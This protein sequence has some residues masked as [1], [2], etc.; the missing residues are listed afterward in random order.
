MECTLCGLPATPKLQYEGEQFCCNGCREVYRYFG[1]IS[2]AKADNEKLQPVTRPEGSEAYLRIDGMHC[3]SCE[4]LIE[5]HALRVK[6]VVAAKTNYATGTLKVIYDPGLI[7]ETDLP[8][9]ISRSGYP[10]RF[11]H[12]KAPAYDYRMP[13][14]RLVTGESLAATVMMLYLAFYY[15]LHL[16][17]I[18]LAE[19]EPVHWLVHQAVPQVL[20]LLTSIMVVYVAAPI[21]RGAWVGL[22]TGVLNMD[23]LLA[24]AILG[25]Y[26]F[27]VA[28]LMLGTL[29]LYFD[30]AAAI[31]ADQQPDGSWVNDNPRWL[32]GDANL[33][34]SYALLALSLCR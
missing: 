33:V 29:E 27:S 5:R 1:G 19:L 14:L 26:G 20:L 3:S 9:L 15:P 2:Q 23:N 34:T 6:G 21:F 7:D 16:G 13:M 24:I 12:D 17:L 28:Q 31:I 4:L 8:A 10:A 32:E 22:R 30:V 11:S 25:A 18:G